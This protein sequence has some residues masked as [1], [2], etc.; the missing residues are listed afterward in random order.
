MV[1]S[2]YALIGALVL[3]NVMLYFERYLL[4]FILELVLVAALIVC[5]MNLYPGTAIAEA[6]AIYK[7]W[8]VT[9]AAIT[10]VHSLHMLL[11]IR[12]KN[13]MLLHTLATSIDS[14]QIN[15]DDIQPQKLAEFSEK[16]SD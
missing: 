7:I 13:N 3:Q 15:Q 5:I 12:K 14:A 4:M 9:N 1:W 16:R 6:Q 10:V 2:L 11:W 8:L